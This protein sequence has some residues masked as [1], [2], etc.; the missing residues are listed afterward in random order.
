MAQRLLQHDTHVALAQAY[1]CELRA[2]RGKQVWRGRQVAD[3]DFGSMPGQACSQR[4]EAAVLCCVDLEVVE[5][6]QE[7]VPVSIG[8]AAG[9]GLAHLRHLPAAR[10]EHGDKACA[11][12]RLGAG[13]ENAAASMQESG[14]MRVEE[15]G[16]ELAARKVS[17]AAEDH[18]IEYGH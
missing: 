3:D 11:V 17:R 15:R 14:S 12:D 4:L 5:P 7:A 9:A 8:S 10:F 6:V 1:P 18:Q 16:N 2:D 13:G